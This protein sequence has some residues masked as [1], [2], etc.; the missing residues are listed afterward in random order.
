MRPRLV[1]L[2]LDG[3]IVHHEARDDARGLPSP[4]VPTRRVEAAI[5]DLGAAG[6]TVVLASGRMYPGTR[7]VH[8][9]LGLR[10][11]LICHQGAA[12]HEPSGAV[13]HEFPLNL[14]IAH[15]VIAL[16]GALGHP[17]EWFT[18]TRYL[19]S[20]ENAASNFYAG[21]SGVR[22]EYGVAPEGSGLHPTGVGII[23]NAEEANGI[24]A[25]LV[26]RFG[27]AV[28]VIDFPSVTVCVAANATKG[29]ALEV[30]AT[31]LGIER[32]AVVAVGD[33]VNDVPMLEWAERGYTVSHGDS[34]ARAAADEV[35]DMTE[36]DGVATLLERIA[37]G[38][39][40]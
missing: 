8:A 26:A 24:H 40:L 6:V 13:V 22:P 34:Y 20:A 1:A 4:L 21:L 33:G 23:S 7:R 27:A 25:E 2:D 35:L 3:T 39:S 16:A 11:P 12:V 19:V 17:Y 9:Y 18:P 15:E 14:E 38:E 5:R 32:G 36:D 10:T 30:L 37:R 31:D 29:R 28:H